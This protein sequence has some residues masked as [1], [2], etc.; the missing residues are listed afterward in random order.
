MSDQIKRYDMSADENGIVFSDP[1]F[2]GDWVLYED[3]VEE[4]CKLQK[5]IDNLYNRMEKAS[6]LLRY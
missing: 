3:H 1:S 2:S 4:V 6:D 5:E